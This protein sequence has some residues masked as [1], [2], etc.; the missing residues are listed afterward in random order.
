MT[1]KGQITKGVNVEIT[2][3]AVAVVLFCCSQFEPSVMVDLIYRI[4]F[5]D[6]NAF[7][8]KHEQNACANEEVLQLEDAREVHRSTVS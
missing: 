7:G 6:N 5:V 3:E 2:L 1:R 8:S 4:I